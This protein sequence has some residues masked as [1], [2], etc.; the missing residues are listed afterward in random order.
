MT[1][2]IFGGATSY[3]KQ[4]LSD[5]LN[6]VNS[7]VDYT[8]STRELIIKKHAMLKQCGYWKKIPFNFQITIIS[9]EDYFNTILGDMEIIK[10]AIISGKITRKEVRLLRRIGLTA[11]KFNEQYGTT[12]KESN[13]WK[14]YSNPNF[15]NTEEIYNEGR[16]YFITLQDASN[17]AV[18][19]KDYIDENPVIN[20]IQVSGD[21]INNQIQQGSTYVFNNSSNLQYIDQLI[22]SLLNTITDD[23]PAEIKGQIKESVEAI[24]GELAKST[25]NRSFIKTVLCG[26]K[27]IKDS[28]EFIAA[29]A[30]IFDFFGFKI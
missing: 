2:C 11:K 24:R 27:T 9:S 8:F 30:A 1:Q 15:L 4:S 23:F 18:R 12:Y 20:N 6:D 16:E 21:M 22:T 17:A 10:K 19:L 14:D 26:L 7:W 3:E 13:K 5:I 28:A 29:L 25:P